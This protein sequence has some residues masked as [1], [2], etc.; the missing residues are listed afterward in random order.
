MDFAEVARRVEYVVDGGTMVVAGAEGPLLAALHLTPWP[1][2]VRGPGPDG[3]EIEAHAL[4][5]VGYSLWEIDGRCVA[6]AGPRDRGYVG[7]V[8]SEALVEWISRQ[9]PLRVR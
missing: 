5:G 4:T 1:E 8:G 3:G 7:Y 6:L 2:I 9:V